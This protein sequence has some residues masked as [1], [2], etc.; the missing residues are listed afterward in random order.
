MPYIGHKIL[1]I[2]DNIG[3]RSKDSAED[4]SNTLEKIGG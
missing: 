4:F 1:E 3:V 2:S